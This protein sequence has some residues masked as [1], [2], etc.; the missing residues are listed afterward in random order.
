MIRKILNFFRKKKPIQIDVRKCGVIVS[1][2]S[3]LDAGINDKFN[4]K[5]VIYEKVSVEGET[6]KWG[7]IIEEIPYTEEEVRNLIKIKEIP[8]VEKEYDEEFEF[9][10]GPP[11]GEILE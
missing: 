8:I 5:I 11:F 4:K 1:T 9:K 6:I 7:K 10:E 3:S 2:E